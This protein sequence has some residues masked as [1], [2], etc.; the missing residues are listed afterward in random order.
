MILRL[1]L[2]FFNF[3]TAEIFTA[4]SLHNQERINFGAP[5]GRVFLL[6]VLSNHVVWGIQS[7]QVWKYR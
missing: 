1:D 2:T 4:E 7:I 6:F 5:I 3:F